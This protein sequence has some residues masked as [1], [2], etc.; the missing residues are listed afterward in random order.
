MSVLYSD[1][2]VGA[3][4]PDTIKRASLRDRNTVI[5]SIDLRTGLALST[6]NS[7]ELS[8]NLSQNKWAINGFIS[9]TATI[10]KLLRDNRVE[11]TSCHD[12]H[13]KNL[14]N[15]DLDNT[16]KSA[17]GIVANNDGLFLRRVG[18]NAG[19]GVCRTCHDK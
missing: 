19:S 1:G 14:S 15:V 2:N 3:G 5:S 6:T 12:P 8:A 17:Y 13:F 7:T 9:D 18:G 4:A 11:C 10:S 16:T